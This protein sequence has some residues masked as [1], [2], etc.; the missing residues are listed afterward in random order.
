MTVATILRCTPTG[1]FW[2]ARTVISATATWQSPYVPTYPGQAEF[3][4]RQLHTSSYH[5]AADFRGQHVVVGRG[6]SAAQIL[7]GVSTVAETTWC[8]RCPPRFIPDDVDGR[9]LFDVATQ[10]RTGTASHRT[11]TA[12]S[13]GVARLGD[14]VMTPTSSPL[15][16]ATYCTPSRSSTTSPHMAWFGLM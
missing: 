2:H 9:V 7:A 4:G 3:A 5:A 11:G 15:A 13:D 10:H 8:T 12:E 1:R 16:T 14:I 6:N